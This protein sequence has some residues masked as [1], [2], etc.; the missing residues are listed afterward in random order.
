MHPRIDETNDRA[1]PSLDLVGAE[2]I[3]R[4]DSTVRR[5]PPHEAAAVIKRKSGALFPGSPVEDQLESCLGVQPKGHPVIAGETKAGGVPLD[6][7]GDLVVR[8]EDGIPHVGDGRLQG[9]IQ[10][11]DEGFNVF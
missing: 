1:C 10:L 4:D 2:L 6:A 7:L 5:G 9:M 8:S 3:E 11:F